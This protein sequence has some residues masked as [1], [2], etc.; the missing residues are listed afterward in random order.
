MQAY[1][2]DIQD[3]IAK[4]LCKVQQQS[5]IDKYMTNLETWI[6]HNSE[7]CKIWLLSINNG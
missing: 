4:V 1:L 6:R 7:E 5:F 3:R 2:I